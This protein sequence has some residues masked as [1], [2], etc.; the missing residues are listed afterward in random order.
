VHQPLAG[1]RPQTS[2]ALLCRMPQR[3]FHCAGTCAS[4]R[5]RRPSAE[6]TPVGGTLWRFCGNAR[7]VFVMESQHSDSFNN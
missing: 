4:D 3:K 6:A 2:A 7:E 5:I 1:A